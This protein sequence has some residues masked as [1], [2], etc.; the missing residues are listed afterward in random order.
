MHHI[1]VMNADGSSLTQLTN[2]PADDTEPAWSL[3]GKR[4][5][6]TSSRD[7]NKEIYLMNADGSNQTRLT[8]DPGID[9]C[10]TWSPDGRILFNST[11]DKM[12]GIYV[13]DSDGTNTSRLTSLA[14]GQPACSPGGGRF[15]FVG[16]SIEKI[17]GTFPPQVF[18][19]D[20]D[21]KNVSM[22]TRYPE[23]NGEPC[24]SSDGASIVF[25]RI[26]DKM[27]ARTN[28][29]QMDSSG[30]NVRRLTAGPTGDRAPALSPDGS[31]LAFQSNRAGNYE[32]YVMSLR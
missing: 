18:V 3:D 23:P 2:S 28:L 24:W 26:V 32:I 30:G 17:G 20:A 25:A 19:S 16:P 4:I 10:P 13:M 12:G 7:G 5:A 6:F 8:T 14:A 21:G 27:G 29:F 31:K 22:L 11:R 9:I 15:A 1:Y